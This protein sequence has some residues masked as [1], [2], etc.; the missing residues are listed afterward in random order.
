[1]TRQPKS[2]VAV[3]VAHLS[4]EARAALEPEIDLEVWI[5]ESL[6]AARDAWP[7]LGQPNDA[8]I[9]YL[10]H[11]VSGVPS[12][13]AARKLRAS[14]LYLAFGCRQSDPRALATF[15]KRYMS[16]AER[17][18][19]KMNVGSAAALDL[20]SEL[21]ELMFIARVDRAPVIEMYSGRGELGAWVR[22]V[23]ARA[24]AKRART[25][26]K[27]V[28]IDDDA[29]MLAATGDPELEYA[30]KLYMGEVRESLHRALDATD[31]RTRTLLRRHYL[32]GLGI[33]ALGTLY[34]VH[35]ATVARWLVSAREALVL[36]VRSDLSDRL[37]LSP[38]TLE[39]V[40]HL[41]GAEM[42]TVTTGW[43]KRRK[44]P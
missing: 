41:A 42:G 25:A 19:A 33:D 14:D 15:N 35:R 20:R 5:S 7:E 10:A 39:S 12:A 18:F 23:A 24:A 21:V 40:M 34:H 27:Q 11:K 26:D 44:R 16:Q 22:S 8:F 17:V 6:A 29:R 32:D 3:F 38:R 2:P 43:L 13:D 36:A 37:M 9:E 31:G 4:K 28:P 30:K 1:M